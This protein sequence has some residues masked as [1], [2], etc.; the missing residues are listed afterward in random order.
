MAR[1]PVLFA[2]GR[3]MTCDGPPE[4]PLGIIDDGY[5]VVAEG[6]IQSVGAHRPRSAP[7]QVIDLGGRLLT[8]GLIDCHTHLPFLGDRAGEFAMR[9]RG[10]SYQEIAA[11]GGGIASTVAATRGASFDELVEVI[12]NRARRLAALGVTTIEAK[13]GYD[14]TLAGEERLLRAIAAAQAQLPVSLCPTLLAHVVPAEHR[15]PAARAA[16]VAQF[17]A[18]LVPRVAEA[19]LAS[20]V[21]VYCDEGAFSLDETRAI[22]A[23]A[24]AA[25]LGVRAHVGQFADVGGAALLA[26]LGGWSADHLEQIG[27][28]DIA[29]LA[30]A[31]VVA[32]MIPTSCVQLRQTPPP[33]AALRRRRVPMA[34]A[35]DWNP[36]T[37]WAEGLAVPMWL[38]ATHYGLTVE[39]TWLGVTRNAAL[40]LRREDVGVLR[41]GARADFVVWDTAEPAAIPYRVGANLAAEVWTAGVKLA[42]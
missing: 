25:G 16:W 22:L 31:G 34:V 9:A 40:A 5:L 28:A 1:S 23:A 41:P 12:V 10:A 37:S 13:S 11:A 6:K 4:A 35:S 17:A 27:E 2:N 39:E 26:E 20:S 24:C 32:V 21:D 38:A 15:E 3:V 42:P 30:A 29:G 7:M 19:A 18:Q 33:V 8:P 14:L 36:G